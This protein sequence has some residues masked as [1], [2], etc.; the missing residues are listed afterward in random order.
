MVEGKKASLRQSPFQLA[1]I[2]VETMYCRG[3]R[4][5]RQHKLFQSWSHSDS[6]HLLEIISRAVPNGKRIQFAGNQGE[7]VVRRKWR[8]P[9]SRTAPARCA[10]RIVET[11][12]FRD[13]RVHHSSLPPLHVLSLGSFRLATACIIQTLLSFTDNGNAA[14]VPGVRPEQQGHSRAWTDNIGEQVHGSG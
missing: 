7:M 13:H 8:E 9:K 12:S 1:F 5:I 6:K 11:L 4:H 14:G 2:S 10:S 3:Q